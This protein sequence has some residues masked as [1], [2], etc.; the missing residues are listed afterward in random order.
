MEHLKDNVTDNSEEAKEQEA[1]KKKNNTLLLFSFLVL[2]VIVGIYGVP[3]A[4]YS[5]R[6]I[7]TDDAFIEGTIVYV[8]PEVTGRIIDVPVDKNQKVQ[9][10]DILMKIDSA[11]YKAAVKRAE[12]ALH[13]TWAQKEALDAQIKQA[14]GKLAQAEAAVEAAEAEADL[15]HK[16]LKRYEDLLNEGVI[17]QSRYD[18]IKARSKATAAKLTEAKQMVAEAQA[19]I[20]SIEKQK[21]VLDFEAK[22]AQAALEEAKLDLN[23]TTLSSPVDGTIAQK[24]AEVGKLAVAG[25]PAFA[26]VKDEP[27]WITANFKETQTEKIRIGQEADIRVDAYPGLVLKGHVESFQPGTGAIFSLLPPEN[28]SGNFVKVVQRVPVRIAIDT[29]EDPEYPL[30]PGLSVVVS[31]KVK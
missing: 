18:Q 27:L 22:K 9:K 1:P 17:P 16:D 10:G 25:Q 3:K 28:A 8:S 31:V 4:I 26:I 11:D 20:E 13:S 6:H 14:R 19:L 12:S 23:K 24:Q 2:L 30:R 15:A 5:W 29:P 21:S 7:S